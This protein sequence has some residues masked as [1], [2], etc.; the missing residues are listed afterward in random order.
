MPVANAKEWWAML[1]LSI[2]DPRPQP[3]PRARHPDSGLT[4]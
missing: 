4:E 1:V 2:T 3:T